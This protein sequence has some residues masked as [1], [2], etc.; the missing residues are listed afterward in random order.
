MFFNPVLLWMCYNFHIL[1]GE[2][3]YALRVFFL[4]VLLCHQV[5]FNFPPTFHII[6]CDGQQCRHVFPPL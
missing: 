5:I 2:D 3:I 4:L 1:G 6:E